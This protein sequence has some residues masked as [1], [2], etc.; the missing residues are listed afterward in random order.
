MTL[1]QSRAP[2]RIGPYV[3][4]R[5][6]GRGG[7]GAVYLA[8]H[9]HTGEL[10][11]AKVLQSPAASV[12]PLVRRE[13]LA[14][15]RLAHPGVVRIAD[16]G[17]EGGLPWYAMSYIEGE[18]L[19]DYQAGS[20]PRT[21]DT[22]DA[23]TSRST[24]VQ[25]AHD[26]D[27][28]TD[29]VANGAGPR[30]LT[31]IDPS[32]LRGLI[33][34]IC[35]LCSALA[36]MHGEGIVHRDLKPQNVMIGRDGLPI[37]VDFGLA[38]RY[39][40]DESREVLELDGLTAGTLA[41]MAPEQIM[42]RFV[43]PRADLYSLGCMIYSLV[44]GRTPFSGASGAQLVKMHLEVPPTPMSQIV[45]PLPA[46]LDEL[47][48]HLLA[49]DP[50]SRIGHAQDVERILLDL[51]AEPWPAE[52]RL[53]LPRLYLYRPRLAGRQS[54]LA[55]L[56]SSL[57]RLDRGG[58][59]LLLVRGESGVGKTRLLMELGALVRRAR[60]AFLVG[61]CRVS[62]GANGAGERA[63]AEPLH[64]FRP[65]LQQ[66]ADTCRESGLEETERILGSR[67]PILAPFEPSLADL[68]GQQRH[69]YPGDL[70]YTESQVRLFVSLAETLEAYACD[71]PFALFIDDLQW[72]DGLSVELIRF[73][74][75]SGRLKRT[76]MLM[77]GTYRSDE[78]SDVLRELIETHSVRILELER[79]NREGTASMVSDMLARPDP[80]VDLVQFMH[81]HSEGNPFFVAEYLR[82]AVAERL[83]Q[84]DGCGQWV[85]AGQH[86][87][88]GRPP[89]FS[90]LP[91]PG[92]IYG[93]VT[94]RLQALSGMAARAV[95]IAAVLGRVVR[96]DALAAVGGMSA[97]ELV[98]CSLELLQRQVLEEVSPDVFRFGHDKL[99]EV[100]YDT[101][102]PEERK[103][104][105]RLAAAWLEQLSVGGE[106]ADHAVL[107]RHL[108]HAGELGRAARH[109]LEGGRAAA[110]RFAHQ[111]AI[112]LY[113]AAIRLAETPDVVPAAHFELATRVL[114]IIRQDR[115]ALVV[116]QAGLDIALRGGDGLAVGAFQ[117]KLAS[118][119]AKLRRFAEAEAICKQAMATFAAA[120]SDRDV[121]IVLGELAVIRSGQGRGAE[122]IELLQA[123]LQKH[124]ELGNR[125]YEAI[126]LGNLATGRQAMGDLS[127]AAEHYEAALAIYA[128]VPSRK[129]QFIML[130]NLAALRW[131]MGDAAESRR[132]FERSL[133]IHRAMGNRT[134]QAAVLTNLAV[135]AEDR[136]DY[137]GA[138]QLGKEA[139]ALHRAVGNARGESQTLTNLGCVLTEMEMLG[140]ARSAFAEA[141]CLCRALADAA[142]EAAALV[143]LGRCERRLAGELE[144]AEGHLRKAMEI[145]DRH[146]DE[147]LKARALCELAHVALARRA[148]AT[149]YV[150]QVEQYCEAEKLGA[151]S[152]PRRALREVRAAIDA[153]ERGQE[154][155][156]GEAPG[157]LP[158]PQTPTS[159]PPNASGGG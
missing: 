107:A 94:R 16:S 51:G 15:S 44:V 153:Q 57:S 2:A 135:L 148:S 56:K 154:L 113:R 85:V 58:G 82:S 81:E 145:L 35:R 8:R 26:A 108:E 112:G 28:P 119:L 128:E 21:S 68:P 120:G 133:A 109:Y 52:A 41:F 63:P 138:L 131:S 3:I 79:L 18:T 24:L 157:A 110:E 130:S 134:W 72:A 114:A 1:P 104:L 37:L 103:R 105:H 100:A 92:S 143:L 14:L 31:P 32:R 111:D 141:L 99:R 76:G 117:Q 152:L 159:V 118:V 91:V 86:E 116:L 17:T 6:L 47:V 144:S 97:E 156:R 9:P 65:I 74:L 20:A 59:E 46:A 13:I 129:H 69:D 127:A 53:P 147:T 36:Y 89:D 67:G 90:A 70:N 42:G 27:T 10:V 38:H 23:K 50:A 87:S 95:T 150:R 96:A 77:I 122:A 34:I 83:L 62:F 125:L 64:P 40:G 60:L 149:P 101:T 93:L 124:R 66:V 33:T 45:G 29:P 12:L 139:L 43:D 140:Q 121:A 102:P 7:I 5:E 80:P 98:D 155:V 126:T 146:G 73:L 136:G 151:A 39:R 123:A 4:E 48:L 19:A 55:A 158:L 115:E 11:A 106:A 30:A 54:A 137:G 142:G 84:R 22:R 71:T 88:Q 49:K 61:E 75:R 132:L 25:V 78:V